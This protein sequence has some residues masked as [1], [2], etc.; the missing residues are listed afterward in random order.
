M[1]QNQGNEIV[2]HVDEEAVD[3]GELCAAYLSAET[4]EERQN[5]N[6]FS[7]QYTGCCIWSWL[8]QMAGLHI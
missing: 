4:E 2:L 3:L 7:V 1:S 5:I 6:W 8:S